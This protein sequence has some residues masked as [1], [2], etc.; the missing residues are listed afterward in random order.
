MFY[1]SIKQSKFILLANSTL[2]VSAFLE[3]FF[4]SKATMFTFHEDFRLAKFR[5]PEIEKFH[6]VKDSILIKF[7]H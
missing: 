3:A 2:H 4:F 6:Y 7:S 5:C 1:G